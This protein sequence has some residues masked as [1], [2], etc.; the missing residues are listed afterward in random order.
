MKALRNPVAVT[1]LLALQAC[2]GFQ[3]GSE[4]AHTPQAT[5]NDPSSVKPQTFVMRGE[6]ILGHEVRSIV[7]CG[8]QQQY[9]L[10]RHC[11]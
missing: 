3:S 8:S 10:D 6:V 2:S 11:R 5:L 1:T 9:W 7:P 4:Q